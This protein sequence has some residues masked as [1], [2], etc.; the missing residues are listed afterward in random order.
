MSGN[1]YYC[2]LQTADGAIYTC[3][4]DFGDLPRS[5]ENQK[6][7][8]TN[9]ITVLP[10]RVAVSDAVTVRQSLDENLRLILMSATGKR[11][12]EYNQTESSQLINMPGVQGVYM[13][14]I[15]AESDVQTVKIVV[16]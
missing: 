11:V 4:S 15:E 3:E 1:S 13:L 2:Q 5:A 16:Y 10:N 6:T 7:Q 9:H 14:R 8:T 12:A